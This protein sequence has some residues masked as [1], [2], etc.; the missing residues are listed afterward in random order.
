MRVALVSPLHE[1]VPPQLYGGTERVVAH[2]ADELVDQGHEVT[3]YA[4]ADSQ[5]RARLVPMAPRGL[6]LDPTVRDPMAHHIAMVP[7]VMEDSDRYD[8]VHFHIDYVHFPAAR[9]AH[10]PCLTTLH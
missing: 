2:L 6:R 10:L 1:S 7:H 3:L 5:T 8:V 4:T 9:A